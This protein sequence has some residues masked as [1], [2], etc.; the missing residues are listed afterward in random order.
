MHA[1]HVST[2][3]GRGGTNLAKWQTWTKCLFVEMKDNVISPSHFI[4]IIVKK[5]IFAFVITTL[6]TTE[7]PCLLESKIEVI[8]YVHHLHFTP[9]YFLSIPCIWPKCPSKFSTKKNSKKTSSLNLIERNGTFWI[10]NLSQSKYYNLKVEW[11]AQN[12]T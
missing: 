4:V 5:E 12:M 7:T 6:Q 2:Q 11:R 3:K 9:S 1:T 10:S 8:I